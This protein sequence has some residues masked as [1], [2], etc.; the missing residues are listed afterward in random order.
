MRITFKLI[1]GRKGKGQGEK[2]KFTTTGNTQSEID[3]L[4]QGA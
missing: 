1:G 4:D 2:E 3:G